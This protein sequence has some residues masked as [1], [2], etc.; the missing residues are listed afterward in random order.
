MKRY[1]TSSQEETF[2]TLTDYLTEKNAKILISN[3]PDLIV[4]EFGVYFDPKEKNI[5][6]VVKAS[7]SKTDNGSCIN[8][9]FNFTKNFIAAFTLVTILGVASLALAYFFSN[10]NFSVFFDPF[11]R[12]LMLL[13]L[14]FVVAVIIAVEI[15]SALKTKHTFIAEFEMFAKSTPKRNGETQ[16]TV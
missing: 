8:F 1:I 10:L 7:I 14:C 16:P 2:Q 5:K 3:K 11:G 9:N 4:A 15:K 6:G 12:I 13:F